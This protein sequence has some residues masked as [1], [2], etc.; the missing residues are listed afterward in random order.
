MSAIKTVGL[1][2]GAA[3]LAYVAARL[4]YLGPEGTTIAGDI[5]AALAPAV[6]QISGQLG[7]ALPCPSAEE[8]AAHLG[9]SVYRVRTAMSQSGKDGCHL[10]LPD[11]ANVPE[12]PDTIF[13]NGVASHPNP[14][15]PPATYANPTGGSSTWGGLNNQQIQAAFL[16]SAGGDPAKAQALWEAQH[17]AEVAKNG[18]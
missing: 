6:G 2:A 17:A 1:L 15:G 16:A 10:G 5:T 11:L 8:L 7:P 12:V 14:A 13:V 18:F 4:G 3:G 9:V